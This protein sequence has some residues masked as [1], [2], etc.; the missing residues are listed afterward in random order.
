MEAWF[1]A[2]SKAPIGELKTGVLAD[3]VVQLVEVEG[4]VHGDEVARRGTSI[5]GMQRT[6][7]RIDRFGVL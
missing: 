7:S 5:W 3:V 1:S 2:P 6:G 4:P